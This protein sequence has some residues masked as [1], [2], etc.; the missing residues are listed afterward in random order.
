MESASNVMAEK[1]SGYSSDLGDCN[2]I[3]KE[4]NQDSNKNVSS[5]SVTTIDATNSL[6]FSEKQNSELVCLGNDNLIVVSTSD[7]VLVAD[8]ARAQDVKIVVEQLKQKGFQ[9]AENSTVD[10]RPWGWFEVLTS[11]NNYKVKCIHVKPGAS[12]S[13]QS[14][15][16]RAEH[17]IVVIGTAK[18]FIDIEVKVIGSGES[19]FVPKGAVHR[20]ENIGELP[21]VLVEVQTG[22][23]F[24]EDDIVRYSD[25]YYRK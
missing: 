17:W 19:V 3:W 20:M 24:G 14:H 2:S 10:Y 1:F 18:V 6:L 12:L 16:Y 21:M 7:A 22:T 23:Y 13:L 5:E 25:I 4:G 15:N 9:Q 8:K 11:D